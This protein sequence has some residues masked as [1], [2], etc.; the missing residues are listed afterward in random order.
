MA[1]K[2]VAHLSDIHIAAK[3]QLTNKPIGGLRTRLV[4]PG[5]PLNPD[6]RMARFELAIQEARNAGAEHFILSGDLTETGHPEE[7]EA[8]AEALDRLELPPDDVTLVPGNHDCYAQPD[9]FHRAARGPL[10]RWTSVGGPNRVVDLET[11]W[12][13]PIDVT[14]H[15]S[16]A[17]ATG[18]FRTELVAPLRAMLMDARRQGIPVVIVQHHAPFPRPWWLQPFDGLYGWELLWDL[19]KLNDKTQVTFGHLHRSIDGPAAEAGAPSRFLG[20]PAVLDG[21]HEAHYRVYD[22]NTDGL[23][24][25]AW[26][27]PTHATARPWTELNG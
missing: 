27:D 12:L 1:V 18:I 24:P 8:F 20:A 6:A 10:A 13:L 15:Q 3:N 2:R 4:S 25:S 11:L 26:P 21:I 19:L 5:R 16:V 9:A 22:V 17:R 14:R 7:F 23:T